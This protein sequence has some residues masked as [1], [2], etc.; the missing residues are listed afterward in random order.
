MTWIEIK[1]IWRSRGFL[2][3]FL[4]PLKLALKSCF[5]SGKITQY[6][7]YCYF[8][9]SGQKDAQKEKNAKQTKE[10]QGQ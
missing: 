2:L 8:S 9:L 3:T 7:K 1:E 10:M 5:D 6:S 4:S